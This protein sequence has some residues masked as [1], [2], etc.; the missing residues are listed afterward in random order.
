MAKLHSNNALIIIGR[1]AGKLAALKAK[2]PSIVILKADLAATDS[3]ASVATEII[4]QSPKLDLLI[5]NAAVQYTP[6]F[7]D[8]DFRTDTI[9][10]EIAV[11][12]TSPCILVSLLLPALLK[13]TPSVILSIN[14]GL[15]L[16]P[17]KTSAVYCGTKG[18]LNIFTQSLRHQL[19]STN[20]RVQQAFMPLV[21]TAMTNGRGMAKLT[22]SNAAQH[23]LSGIEKD[24]FRQLYRQSQIPADP[25]PGFARHR[26]THNEKGLKMMSLKRF[27][28]TI[29]VFTMTINNAL[30]DELTIHVTGV[31]ADRGG[32]LSVMV[33]EKN[34]YPKKHAKAP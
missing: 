30:A 34:G 7:T 15:G 8:A 18:G 14:S 10:E 21:D 19:A 22:P 5:N 23:I 2:F 32:N 31:E 16:V 9:A 20:V 33:F 6:Q 29:G 3:L 13:D 26:Y 17:K 27:I 11:N 24:V 4:R 28:L 12:F 1:N 25:Q